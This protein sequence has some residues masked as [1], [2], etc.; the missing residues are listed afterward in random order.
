MKKE[1]LPS[2][3]L[4]FVSMIFLCTVYPAIVWAVAQVTPG[5]GR[6]VVIEDTNGKQYFENIGQTFSDDSYFWSRPSAVDYDASSTGGSNSGPSNPEYLA[7]VQ[8]RIDTF[9]AHHPGISKKD[10]PS[11]MVTAGGS[12]LDPHISVEGAL[13]QVNRVAQVRNIPASQVKALVEEYT[14]QP[15]LDFMGT[16]KVNVLKL[17]IALNKICE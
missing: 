2:L 11:D 4:T 10:I 12:G 3:I 5:K 15:L 14:E 9:L 1:L 16:Q 8:Q 17:N 13:I 6:G 7:T